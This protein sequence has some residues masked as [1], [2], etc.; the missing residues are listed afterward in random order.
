MGS[1]R[2][3]K[4]VYANA[5]RLSDA[6]LPDVDA[7]CLGMGLDVT[8]LDVLLVV[9][10]IAFITVLVK[11][12]DSLTGTEDEDGYNL[13]RGIQEDNDPSRITNAC[14]DCQRT[15]GCRTCRGQS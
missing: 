14:K 1:T 11:A 2:A 13:E 4:S 8:L 6:D 15:T 12:A 9:F 5:W 3:A 10:V 7:A